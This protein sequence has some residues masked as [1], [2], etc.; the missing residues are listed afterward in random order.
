MGCHF[1]LRLLEEAPFNQRLD[2]T[3]EVWVLFLGLWDLVSFGQL[4]SSLELRLWRGCA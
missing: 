2:I 4:V 3:E 1:P